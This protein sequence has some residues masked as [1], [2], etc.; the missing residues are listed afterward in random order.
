[1]SYREVTM[2]EIKEAVR[3]WLARVPK[4]RIAR[5]LGLDPKTV[6]RYVAAAQAQGLIQGTDEVALTEEVFA[7]LLLALEP[8]QERPHG[9]SWQLCEQWREF[10]AGHLGQRVRLTKIRRL[11]LRQGVE[12]PYATLHRFSVAELGFGRAAATVPVADGEPGHEVQLDTGWMTYLEPDL[13]GKRRRLPGLDL[14]PDVSR[15]RFVY[16]CFQGDHG[17]RDR[18]LRSGLGVLR[19]GLP[20]AD[21]R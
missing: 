2:F 15:Y 19:R 10:V 7:G 17:Q 16:P 12:I 8:V 20:R 5:Q 18:G 1:M 6:R 14:H 13:F 4:K 9:D 21:P 3:L 11:L